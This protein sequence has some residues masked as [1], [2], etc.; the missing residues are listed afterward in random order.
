[1]R[2]PLPSCSPCTWCASMPPAL[3]ASGVAPPPPRG[4]RERQIEQ[5]LAF[6][7]THL[8]EQLSLDLVAQK[9]G[10]SPYY[11]ARLFQRTT[12]ETVHQEVLRQRLARAAAARRDHAAPG[13]HR[14]G[15]WLR[16]SELLHARLKTRAGCAPRAYRRERAI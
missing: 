7:R 5:V 12:G 14:W 8:R 6:I 15:A 3:Q 4:L 9:T 11:F 2:T 1:M 10:Y 13:A 16:Q